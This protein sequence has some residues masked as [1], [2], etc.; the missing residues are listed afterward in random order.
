MLSSVGNKVEPN[1]IN[2][3]RIDPFKPKMSYREK[4]ML[5]DSE[6]AEYKL[7]KQHRERDNNL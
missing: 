6:K 3:L 4:L 2:S 5:F 1:V 7:K